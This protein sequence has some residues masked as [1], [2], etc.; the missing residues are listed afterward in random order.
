MRETPKSA[1]ATSSAKQHN[2]STS[3]VQNTPKPV[4]VASSVNSA[5]SGRETPPPREGLEQGEY[6]ARSEGRSRNVKF[7]QS[8]G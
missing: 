5:A 6:I 1:F 7:N 8:H 4:S 2:G 3:Q